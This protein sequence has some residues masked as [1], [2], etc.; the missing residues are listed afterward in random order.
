MNGSDQSTALPKAKNLLRS[1]VRINANKGHAVL[2]LTC[3][4][5]LSRVFLQAGE[6]VHVDGA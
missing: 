3:G 5:E 1:L 2:H 6:V 4:A